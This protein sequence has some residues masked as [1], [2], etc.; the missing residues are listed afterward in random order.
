MNSENETE[1]SG[2][3]STRKE[4]Y[5]KIKKYFNDAMSKMKYTQTKLKE[6]CEKRGVK[7]SQGTISKVLS[8]KDDEKNDSSISLVLATA[9]CDIL[10]LDMNTVLSLETPYAMDARKMS[11]MEKMEEDLP[12]SETLIA[13]PKHSAFR[14]YLDETLD[15]YFYPTISYQND[16]LKGKLSFVNEGD[17]LC[18][19]TMTIMTEPRNKVYTGKLLISLQQNACY[20]VLSSKELGEIGTIFFRH[21]FFSG[22]TLKIRLAVCST[23]SAGDSRRPTIH[24]M[25]MCRQ[26]E[27]QTEGQMRLIASQLLLNDS[28]IRIGVRE[29]DKLAQN[30]GIFES[31]KEKARAKEEVVRIEESDVLKM[32]GYS[33][34]EIVDA[35]SL[36]RLHSF[37][38]QRYNK[39]S[40]K[41]DDILFKYLF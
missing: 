24:R 31:I 39:S 16:I 5:K 19:V 14:G 25:M 33:F 2:I 10:E 27:I 6:E 38:P 23:I 41:S 36:M 9:I 20:C 7:V 18:R 34:D 17:R 12:T 13:D 8:L 22:S 3:S 4:Y 21:R 29:L 15:I 40:A 26:G 32:D 37:D 1:E 28:Q 35:I 11:E 30:G